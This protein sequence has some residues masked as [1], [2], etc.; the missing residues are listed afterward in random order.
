MKI[1]S[2]EIDSWDDETGM[3][4]ICYF[5]N[6]QSRDVPNVIPDQLGLTFEQM[7]YD[8]QYPNLTDRLTD[9]GRAAI[10]EH[11]NDH[12]QINV[13]ESLI[14]KNK[15]LVIL[16]E[17]ARKTIIGHIHQQDFY[18][19]EMKRRSDIMEDLG[20]MRSEFETL[21]AVLKERINSFPE[22]KKVTLSNNLLHF[23]CKKYEDIVHRHLADNKMKVA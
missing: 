4:L 10:R 1:T 6:E 8:T 22:Y 14:E 12:F 23:M 9:Q 11:L 5:D 7:F 13:F 15:N 21:T 16:C 3:H 2:F 19:G 20:A 18:K 17:E